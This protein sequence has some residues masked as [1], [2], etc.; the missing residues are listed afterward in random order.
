MEPAVPDQHGNLEVK[1]P[2][3]VSVR[4]RFP[5]VPSGTQY[6]KGGGRIVGQMQGAVSIPSP[7][8]DP[9]GSNPSP[10]TRAPNGATGSSGPLV[11]RADRKAH[12]AF[13]AQPGQSTRLS[14]ERSPVRIRSG[15]RST[16]ISCDT[17]R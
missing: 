17:W 15:A 10:S 13:V 11:V 4:V 14:S 6:S 16:G 2:D 5:P 8:G 9:G 1:R 3:K 12:P 7:T